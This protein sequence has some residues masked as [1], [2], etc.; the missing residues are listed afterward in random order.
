METTSTYVLKAKDLYMRYDTFSK[1]RLNPKSCDQ[2]IP[3]NKY[4]FQVCFWC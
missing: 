2:V 1:E 3:K 4:A